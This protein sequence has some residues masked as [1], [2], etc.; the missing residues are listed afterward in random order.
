[1][2]D[3]QKQ[4][5]GA[6]SKFIQQGVEEMRQFNEGQRTMDSPP[7]ETETSWTQAIQQARDTAPQQEPE[8]ERSR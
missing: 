4:P 2:S 6:F 5:Q 3:E 8:Q 7:I 1:M